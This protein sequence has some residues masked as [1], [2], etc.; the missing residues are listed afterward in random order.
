[1]NKHFKT[2]LIIGGIVL[3][4]LIVLGLV[5]GPMFGGWFGGWGMMGP[6]MMGGFSG[7]GLMLLVW[8]V[9]LGL[10]IWAIL[11]AVRHPVESSSS[12]DSAMNV[13]KS[14]YAHGEINK[15]E[16]EQKKKNL[17]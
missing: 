8:I 10:I 16:Y 3:G 7:M 5:L 13:L 12:V 6:G 14:R 4:A 2:A 17:S 11:S 15:E 9:V 1:V